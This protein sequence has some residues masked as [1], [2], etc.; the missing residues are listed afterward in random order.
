MESQVAGAGSEDSLSGNV[1][2]NGNVSTSSQA[3]PQAA[4]SEIIAVKCGSATGDF[5]LEKFKGAT[6]SKG[7][8]KCILSR[9][10]WFTPVE[11]ESLGGKEKSKNWR[12]SIYHGNSQLGNY[13]SSRADNAR[14]QSP[15]HSSSR[16]QSPAP[17]HDGSLIPPVSSVLTNP[18]LAFIKAYRLRGDVSGLRNAL[19]SVVDSSLLVDAHKSFWQHCKNDLEEL[20]LSFKNRRDSDKRSVSDAILGDIIVAFDALDNASK[21][22][23]IFV[24]A[25][26]LLS[27]PPVV[28]DPIAKKLSENTSSID[29][30]TSVV[31]QLSE[32]FSLPPADTSKTTLDNL[33]NN[34]QTQLESLSECIKTLSSLPSISPP[35][36]SEVSTA[37]HLHGSFLQKAGAGQGHKLLNPSSRSNRIILFNL[38]EASLIETKSAIDEISEYLI[39]KKVNIRNAI[40]LGRRK[41]PGKDSAPTRPR[42]IL[43]TLDSDWG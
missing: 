26:D 42:P 35:S 30:L 1:S 27:I 4:S 24:E 6:G 40:R 11:F 39:G 28:L 23:A 20:G 29:C 12:R 2:L 37:G 15:I 14:G 5:Y 8:V 16:S 25:T 31:S 32:K 17:V 38:P 43:I 3:L 18:I 9:S 13:L 19:L 10:K 7:G 34:I 41:P 22:P 36:T 21:L 33:A